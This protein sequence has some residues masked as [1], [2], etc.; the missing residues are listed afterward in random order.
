[1]IE[2]R[3]LTKSFGPRPVLQGIDLNIQSGGI[4]AV[5][6]PNGSGKTTIIKTILGMVIPDKGDILVQGTSIRGDWEYR[7]AIDYL[8]QIVRFPEN[9]KVKELVK[10]VKDVRM[11]EA[12]EEPLIE[13]FG[14]GTCLTQKLR[15]LSGGT[16]QKVNVMLTFMFDSPILI[17]DEPTVGL[18]P[19]AL[20]KLKEL[21]LAQR[22]A[23]KTILLT[24]HIMNLVEELA[25]QIVFLLEGKI[26]FQGTLAQINEM[27]G[28]KNLERSIASVLQNTETAG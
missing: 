22:E 8:P 17:L 14:L 27:T 1:M 23:G 19:I 12:N 4:F 18:D 5:L 11:A 15:N 26:Y 7:K 21:I 13:S 2:I 25:D 9:L 3:N 6:G 20:I 16:R 24:T 28:E 10:L